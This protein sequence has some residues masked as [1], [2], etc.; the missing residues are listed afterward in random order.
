M[1]K[2]CLIPGCNPNY[3]NR[4]GCRATKQKTLVFRLSRDKSEYSRWMKAMPHT[5]IITTQDSVICEKHWPESYPTVSIKE[6]TR[7]KY[8]PSVWPGVPPSCVPRPTP[9]PRSTKSRPW[10]CLTLSLM[11]WILSE[12]WTRFPT[13]ISSIG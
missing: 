7:P 6:R 3:R 9:A 5:N 13:M 1:V 12:K 10:K 11:N 8:P 4:K 2:K